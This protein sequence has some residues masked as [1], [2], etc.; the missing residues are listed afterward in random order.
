MTTTERNKYNNPVFHMKN[1]FLP[2][3]YPG[4]QNILK[5][6]YSHAHPCVA[7]SVI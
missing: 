4:I 3:L 5:C 7:V 1:L 6:G 2:E